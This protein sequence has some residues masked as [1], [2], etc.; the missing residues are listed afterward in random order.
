MISIIYNGGVSG[1]SSFGIT[2]IEQCLAFDKLGCDVYILPTDYKVG[3]EP[4][5]D[6]INKFIKRSQLGWPYKDSVFI[7]LGF[8]HFFTVCAR[9]Q[10]RVKTAIGVNDS[11]EVMDA[12]G[13]N[14]SCT[15]VFGSSD[16][17]TQAYVKAGV[18]IPTYTLPH[19]INPETW[20]YHDR[21]KIDR[22]KFLCVGDH[23]GRK[24]FEEL[25]HAFNKEFKQSEPVELTVKCWGNKIGAEDLHNTFSFNPNIHIIYNEN[26]ISETR[27][28]FHDA[29]CYVMATSGDAIGMPYLES[30]AS[31][32]PCIATSMGGQ[33]QWTRPEFSYLIDCIPYKSPYLAG[34][35]FMPDFEHLKRLMRHAYENPEEVREFGRKASEFMHKN[36]TWELGV[37]KGL[38]II[39]KYL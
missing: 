24:R 25:C 28:Y 8:P 6:K 32:I 23:T 27:Q 37:K 34:N 12:K 15:L 4:I 9:Q 14:E 7:H 38:D 22:F 21:P 2:T 18:T 13:I 17:V 1:N 30:M 16:F 29:D 10:A 3:K 33:T 31:G 11:D 20:Y 35:Q 19:G 26:T 36:Y 39:R 5:P